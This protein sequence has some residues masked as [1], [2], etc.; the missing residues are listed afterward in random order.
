MDNV[1]KRN[2]VLIYYRQKV[3][4]VIYITSV[5]VLNKNRT[6]GNV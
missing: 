3:L 2:I 4:D 5:G 1:Q 6:V